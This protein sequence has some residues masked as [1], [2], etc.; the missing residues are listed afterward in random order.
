MTAKFQAHYF[1]SSKM[2]VVENIHSMI[3]FCF[4]TRCNQLTYLTIYYLI[5]DKNIITYLPILL[6]L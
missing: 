5:F 2:Y 1:S 6:L 3:I 4:I